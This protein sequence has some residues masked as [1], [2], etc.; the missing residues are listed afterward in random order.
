MREIKFRAWDKDYKKIINVDEIDL[1]LNQIRY[2]KDLDEE[3]IMLNK[4][5]FELMQF[6]GLKDKNGKE[7][8]EGDILEVESHGGKE[9]VEVKWNEGYAGWDFFKGE[10]YCPLT[11]YKDMMGFDLNAKIIGNKFENPELLK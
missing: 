4:G 11:D 6:I 2:W 5:D 9:V 1:F 10:E 7:I 3:P 8:Y